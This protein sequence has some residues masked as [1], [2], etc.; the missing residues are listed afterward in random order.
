MLDKVRICCY[1]IRV[2]TCKSKSLGL[3]PFGA[4]SRT[5]D[6][7][8]LAK[9]PLQASIFASRYNIRVNTCKSKSYKF[10]MRNSQCAIK[11]D[12]SAKNPHYEAFPLTR[13]KSKR[14]KKDAASAASVGL[15][16]IDKFLDFGEGFLN[17]VKAVGV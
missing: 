12:F 14:N 8:S 4:R 15:K 10:A 9:M 3:S 6:S 2:N 17:M 7:V 11:V 1:N 5:R 16:R 13:R